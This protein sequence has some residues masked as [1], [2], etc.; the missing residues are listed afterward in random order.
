MSLSLTRSPFA[1]HYGD[2]KSYDQMYRAELS[3]DE[4]GSVAS[5]MVV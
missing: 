4:E 5:G 1:D 3:S 2:E